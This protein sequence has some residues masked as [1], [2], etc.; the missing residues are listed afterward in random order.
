MDEKKLISENDVQ[1]LWERAGRMYA[2]MDYIKND[3]F[4]D[5]KIVYIMLGG[6][7]NDVAG[8]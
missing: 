5:V 3:K 2:A 8:K 6:D 1:E 7:P 4:P